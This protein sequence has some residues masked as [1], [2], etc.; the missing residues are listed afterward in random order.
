MDRCQKHIRREICR[1]IGCADTSRNEALDCRVYAYAALK[2]LGLSG[3][4]LNLF[5]DRFA[6]HGRRVTAAP[7]PKAP[8]EQS[9]EQPQPAPRRDSGANARN[10]FLNGP[11]GHF[12]GG[13]PNWFGR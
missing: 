1:R 9:A 11:G 3:A 13:R 6:K 4:Q 12:L 5:C 8:E 10:P 7:P 2:S